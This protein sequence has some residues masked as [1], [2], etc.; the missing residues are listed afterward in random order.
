MPPRNSG[1]IPEVSTKLILSME[2]S[3]LTWDGTVEPVSQDQFSSANADREII[4][5]PIQLTMSRIGNHT[6]FI[7]TLATCVTIHTYIHTYN[8]HSCSQINVM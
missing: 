4:I 3:S 8:N 6:R 5:S 1:G 7:R 2:M